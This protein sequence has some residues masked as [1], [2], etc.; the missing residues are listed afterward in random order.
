MVQGILPFKYE[1]EKNRDKG[2]GCVGRNEKHI[3]G[4][5]IG[6]LAAS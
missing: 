1:T 5:V 6:E 3:L 2:I 4:L